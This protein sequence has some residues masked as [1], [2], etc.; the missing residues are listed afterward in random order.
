MANKA[1]VALEV[2]G[3]V[4]SILGIGSFFGDA[5]NN[6]TTDTDI[7]NDLAQVKGQLDRF[8]NILEGTQDQIIATA[9]AQSA[10]ALNAVRQYV[11]G[12]SGTDF[13]SVKASAIELSNLGLNSAIQQTKAIMGSAS[14]ETL[15]NAFGAI[16]YAMHARQMVANVM[17]DGPLG[18]P[19]LHEQIKDAAALLFDTDI[20]FEET[21]RDTGLVFV[22]Q[23]RIPGEI[24]QTAPLTY[25]G[26]QAIV[27]ITTTSETTGHTQTNTVAQE[28]DYGGFLGLWRLTETTAEF[29]ARVT[30]RKQELLE[31][32][33]QRDTI[34]LDIAGL[35]ELASEAHQFLSYAPS[36]VHNYEDIGDFSDNS[37]LG[38]SRSDYLSGRD[39][40][41]ELWGGREDVI[42][43]ND[44]PDNL[45]GGAGND[46]LRGGDMSDLMRGGSG[47]DFIIADDMIG[48]MGTN[49]VARFEGLASDYVIDGGTTYATVTSLI[50]GSRDKLFGV[51]NIRFD[52]GVQTLGAGSAL[53]DAGDPDDFVTAEIVA[54]LY[55]A[56]LNRDGNI[57]RSGLNFYID[58]ADQLET[59]QGFDQNQMI[60]FIAEDLM[61]SPEFTDNF[62]NVNTLT[63]DE[64]LTQVYNNVLGRV[65]DGSGFDFYLGYLDGTRADGVQLA[66]QT[67]LADIAISPE[68]TQG[69]TDVLMSL[70]EAT[71]PEVH[72]TTDIVLDWY[73]VA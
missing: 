20:R 46:I 22:I 62:G 9:T 11:D 67:V 45:S 71:T 35:K 58:V 56:A 25:D 15:A 57:D 44:G 60:E 38:T 14:M 37:F 8:A 65:P 23:D 39:G 59:E 12:D 18:A 54:L 36:N 10:S 49:D 28:G 33:V 17:Q 21:A 63:N 41:D 27:R 43:G 68:N 52:N 6:D 26:S 61:T 53:D 24:T 30:A 64:F 42:G 55:E 47:N 4:G 16:Q 1:K 29:N 48:Q 69:S 72:P 19:G 50:D 13:A 31:D 51:E 32:V 70:Y 34:A 7:L 40:D 73:F 2:L 3:A 5:L 66:K